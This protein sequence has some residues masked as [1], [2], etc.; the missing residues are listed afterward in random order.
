MLREL[1]SG[2]PVPE[3]EAPFA[4]DLRLTLVSRCCGSILSVVAALRCLAVSSL[5]LWC[6]ADRLL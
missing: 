3:E 2:V 6:S 5:P 4:G 1:S